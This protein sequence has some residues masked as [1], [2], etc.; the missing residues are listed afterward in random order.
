MARV[1]EAQIKARG[2]QIKTLK[3]KT[4]AVEKSMLACDAALETLPP[5]RRRSIEDERRRIFDEAL[6]V[7]KKH[8]VQM[9]K[10]Q[11]YEN[12][13]R[14]VK[15][16]LETLKTHAGDATTS[17]TGIERGIKNANVDEVAA[18]TTRCT[19]IE[20]DIKNDSTTL[21]KTSKWSAA[22]KKAL[23]VDMEVFARTRELERVASSLDD[24]KKR[25]DE[26]DEL[27]RRQATMK[28][29]AARAKAALAE[30]NEL[31][32][33][34]LQ[35][36]YAS[37]LK[38]RKAASEALEKTQASIEAI[39]ED[40]HRRHPNVRASLTQQLAL[41]IN[42]RDG[43]AVQNTTLGPIVD[44]LT[45]QLATYDE[46]RAE[47]DARLTAL[48]ALINNAPLS[49]AD[50][51]R[52]AAR[53]ALDALEFQPRIN[54]AQAMVDEGNDLR[55]RAMAREPEM[56]DLA[57]R[58]DEYVKKH[59]EPFA[60]IVAGSPALEMPKLED[61]DQEF[62]MTPAR[63]ALLK[64]T[65]ATIV[66]IDAKLQRQA[67]TEAREWFE[68]EMRLTMPTGRFGIPSPRQLIRRARLK[69]MRSGEIEYRRRAILE[70]LR[71]NRRAAL[72]RGEPDTE[73][74]EAIH[75]RFDLSTNTTE[76]KGSVRA[77]EQKRTFL[78]E[79]EQRLDHIQQRAF[80]EINNLFVQY[81]FGDVDEVAFRETL[82]GRGGIVE[83]VRRRYP[84][85]IASCTELQS[86]NL[87]QRAD[88]VR[89]V[90]QTKNRQILEH[91]TRCIA[92][93]AHL[94]HKLP[95]DHE[96][97]EKQR[98]MVADGL[99][100]SRDTM[101]KEFAIDVTIGRASD[102]HAHTSLNDRRGRRVEESG[103]LE[104]FSKSRILNAIMSPTMLAVG[105]YCMRN[106]AANNLMKKVFTISA[107]GVGAA[108]LFTPAG[109]A[110]ATALTVGAVAG[111]AA[112]IK[113]FTDVRHQRAVVER[114]D[115]FGQLID[116]ATATPLEQGLRR[117]AIPRRVLGVEVTP[118]RVLRE[119]LDMTVAE[120]RLRAMYA[121]RATWTDTD[122][123]RVLD[124][125]SDYE[126]RR[127]IN[128]ERQIDLLRGSAEEHI[129]RDRVRVGTMMHYC[130]S[131]LQARGIPNVS[132]ELRVRRSHRRQELLSGVREADHRARNLQLSESIQTGL[133]AGIPVALGGIILG[134][135][136][137]GIQA[138][139]H[140]AF[141]TPA[142]LGV[143]AAAPVV[144]KLRRDLGARG[145]GL[146][147][148]DLPRP[149]LP[150]DPNIAEEAPVAAPRPIVPAAPTVN[151]AALQELLRARELPPLLPD[152]P[153][154]EAGAGGG[155]AVR[156]ARRTP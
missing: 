95:T 156:G 141:G 105:V 121:Q 50:F 101:K 135:A 136:A 34:K 80:L 139:A 57:G 97:V 90:A 122:C 59:L 110:T 45:T 151:E 62:G 60:N 148:P 79:Q 4:S 35:R 41:L 16:V 107:A 102:V 86:N 66:N 140:A 30:K 153:A 38:E 58:I 113:R 129:E 108:L 20:T 127:R 75:Q 100:K 76:K 126:E 94:A 124:A 53:A 69:L 82:L 15:E 150:G 77:R 92:V 22:L 24:L 81:A 71:R 115:A 93:E 114:R 117:N 11:R 54:S 28:A 74:M 132:D 152:P 109:I 13:N 88:Q 149:D 133:L 142:S 7:R 147:V 155:A 8:A 103:W 29:E 9:R 56:R 44:A 130:I 67:D 111:T 23:A 72:A 104:R 52:V 25:M 61:L 55:A 116:P 26:R 89:E 49:T 99:K 17:L 47:E 146:N 125:I 48:E 14:A 21:G 96:F 18:F 2:E 3:E 143:I 1:L 10:E 145:I 6:Q 98:R 128:E 118:G 87:L 51:D 131:A 144:Y 137:P 43:L 73:E 63:K 106:A 33:T 70:N 91:V 84:A 134:N 12:A 120:D 85:I 27:K 112:G 119:K 154:A 64:K 46:R 65:R 37:L 68:Q 123:S 39:A 36:Q 42:A 40:I 138:A 19:R 83:R 31:V 78:S 5:E 32:K